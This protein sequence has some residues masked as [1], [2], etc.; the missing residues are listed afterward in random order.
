LTRAS[1]GSQDAKEGPFQALINKTKT[2]EMQAFK[3][4]SLGRR[5]NL[6]G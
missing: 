3:K 2:E 1:Q 6:F 4:V 5:S